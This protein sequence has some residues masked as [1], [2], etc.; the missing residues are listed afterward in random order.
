[1]SCC[2]A[3]TLTLINNAGTTITISSIHTSEGTLR[4]FSNG[5]T[6]SGSYGSQQ[7]G[8]AY[9]AGG[10]RGVASGTLTIGLGNP[11][12]SMQLT[13]DFTPKN[14]MGNCPC[15]STVKSKSVTNGN[16]V[17]NAAVSNGSSDGKAAITW[18]IST[19]PL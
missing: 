12:V 11:A 4:S 8:L 13:Y 2:D 18:T 14:N 7:S 9:S 16:F 5:G 15:T 1:M 3:A 19:Q 10:S 17:A 6:I